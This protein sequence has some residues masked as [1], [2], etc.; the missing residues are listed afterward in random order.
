[1]YIMDTY[2]CSINIAF[3]LFSLTNIALLAK[4]SLHK[5]NG[6]IDIYSVNLNSVDS[7]PDH[8]NLLATSLFA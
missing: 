6:S 7:K 5:M 8:S 3:C 2:K 4:L 1:M